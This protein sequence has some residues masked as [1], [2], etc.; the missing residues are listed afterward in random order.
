MNKSTCCIQECESKVYGKLLCS[1]HYTRLVR[2]GSTLE[3]VK[4]LRICRM[5]SCD[6]GT[7]GRKWCSMH[8]SR[9]DKISRTDRRCVLSGCGTFR[10]SKFLCST[11]Y[12][13]LLETGT[14][15]KRVTVVEKCRMP[16]CEKLRMAKGWCSAHYKR[17]RETG[18]PLD[19]HQSRLIPE[20]TACIACGEPSVYGFRRH[21]SMSCYEWSNMDGALASKPCITCGMEFDLASKLTPAGRR[22]RQNAKYCDQ[23]AGGVQLRTFVPMLVSTKGTDC[24][25][26]SN[27]I[28]MGLKYP[29]PMSRAVDHIFPKSLGGTEDMDNL[30][31]AHLSC[32]I[33]KSNR[34]DYV[35][36]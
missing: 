6:N 8:R 13:R 25:I 11:H 15:S 18:S 28:D 1:K 21:C 5:S 7:D 3:K 22:K 19:K 14:T 26:C 30:Q 2:H 10:S 34:L 24:G 17:I 27:P 23:C 29:N 9:F 20:R 32:N 35:A 4:P 33:R 12:S 36:S 31:L 16:K